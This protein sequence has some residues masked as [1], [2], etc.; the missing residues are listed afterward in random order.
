[1]TAP[2]PTESPFDTIRPAVTYTS[3]K[4]VPTTPES[5]WQHFTPTLHWCNWPQVHESTQSDPVNHSR[6]A[7]KVAKYREKQANTP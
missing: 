3:T 7:W 2:L 1:M 6:L 4:Q 5:E